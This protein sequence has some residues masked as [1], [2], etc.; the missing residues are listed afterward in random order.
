[1]GVTGPHLSPLPVGEEGEEAAAAGSV[2]PKG[3]ERRRGN[4]SRAFDDAVVALNQGPLW[5]ARKYMPTVH[6]AE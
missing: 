6:S 2:S 3:R 5:L 4:R 1:M